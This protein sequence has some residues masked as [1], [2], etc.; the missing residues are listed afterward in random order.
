MSVKDQKIRELRERFA[1]FD[2]SRK[3]EFS[4]FKN[5]LKIY[6]NTSSKIEREKLAEE[7]RVRHLELYDFLKKNPELISAENEIMKLSAGDFAEKSAKNDGQITNFF[8]II[9]ENFP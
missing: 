5:F 6:L 9:K 7:F 4:D 1:K 3:S 8:E 2:D